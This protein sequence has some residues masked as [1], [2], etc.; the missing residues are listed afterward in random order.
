MKKIINWKEIAK[1]AIKNCA[2]CDSIKSYYNPFDRC[3]ECNKKFCFDCLWSSQFKKGMRL[4]DELRTICDNCKL[5]YKY[6]PIN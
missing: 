3:D 2:K 5:E 1:S 6:E 4:E